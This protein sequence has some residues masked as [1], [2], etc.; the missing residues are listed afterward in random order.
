M[1]PV[2]RARALL[3]WGCALLVAAGFVLVIYLKWR[4]GTSPISLTLGGLFMTPGMLVLISLRIFRE[5][6]RLYDRLPTDPP[7]R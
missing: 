4:D 7:K 6:F 5:Q 2:F 1:R 3:A